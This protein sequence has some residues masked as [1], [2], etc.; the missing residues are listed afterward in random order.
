MIK[1][2]SGWSALG[3]AALGTI[4]MCVSCAQPGSQAPTPTPQYAATE[5]VV[6]M[7]LQARMTARAPS[8]SPT[9]TLSDL[10]ATSGPRATAT[11]TPAGSATVAPLP[12]LAFARVGQDE[13]MNVVLYDMAGSSAGELLTH[14][15][16]PLNLNDVSWSPDGQ[17]IAFVSSHDYIMSSDNER[18]VFLVRPDGAE[19]RML[20]GNAV[21][22]EDAPGPYVTL[23][24]QVTGSVGSSLVYAQGAPSVVTTDAEGFFQ[25]DGVPA[26]A[27]WV[28]AVSQSENQVLQGYVRLEGSS[29]TWEGVQIPVSAGG[30]GWREVSFS[31]DGAYIAG[32][33]YSW[34][35]SDAGERQY[36]YTGSIYT[37]DGLPSG[38]VQV[39]EGSTLTGL[40]W[41]PVD[42]R[43]V[44]TLRSD[45]K[46]QVWMWNADGTSIGSILDIPDGEDT[47]LTA[48]RPSWSPDGR[49]IVFELHCWYWWSGDKYRTDLILVD[50]DGQNLRTLL[51]NPWGTDALHPS[52]WASSSLVFYQLSSGAPEEDYTQR[53]N[54]DIWSVS[55]NEPTP[56]ALTSDGMSYIPGACPVVAQVAGSAVIPTATPATTAAPAI[57]TL[58]TPTPTAPA[59]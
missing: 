44:G 3:L 49:T 58:A 39:P 22:P 40:T 17:W 27:T 43:L 46:T 19:M 23:A 15:V 52:W 37:I 6:A 8:E 24:G 55:I 7:A 53:S 1:S 28:R 2:R 9:P 5:T 11:P 32:L 36:T 47:V 50:A 42:D 14:F 20:T 54:G 13:A 38:Q 48:A 21:D 25:M 56:R 41:S 30:Q 33:T 26:S 29:D 12:L 18:N 4:L 35:L 59:E 34:T 57:I 16:E 10:K 45:K 31:R 51:E